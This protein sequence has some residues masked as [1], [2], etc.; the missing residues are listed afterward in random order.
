MRNIL[1]TGAKGFIGKNLVT[2][3]KNEKNI[4]VFEFDIN[5]SLDQLK[6]YIKDVDFIFHLAGINRPQNEEE[7]KTGNT[8][9]TKTLVDLVKN[10]KRN[11]PIVV[12]S[13]T[14]AVKDNPY[15]LSKKKAEDILLKH[16]SKGGNVFIYRLPNVFGKWC[17]PNYNSV[18]ATFCHNLARNIEI[19]V[20]NRENKLEFVYIDDV[21]EEFVSILMSEKNNLNDYYEVSVSYKTTLGELED[22]LRFISK[23]RETLMVPSFSD[24]FTRKL[25]ATYLSYLPIDN[26]SYDLKKHSDERGYLFE[27]IKSNEFGQ[28]FI[29][30]T[31][32][33]I[34]RGNHYHHTKFEKFCVI[35]G[36]A[37]IS[38]RHI[39]NNEKVS[40]K[41]NGDN[42]KIVDIPTGYTH[43]ITNVGKTDLITLFWV[44]EVFDPNKMD[45]YFETV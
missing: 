28:I 37:E 12:S 1:V 31:K 39:S 23:N 25:H 33:G 34:T 7:F 2:Q 27:V 43:N 20:S 14:Q 30:T 36:E 13:S 18:V 8:D 42:P 16:K 21:V 4:K 24:D 26:F 38:F 11:I 35:S 6:A 32:P 41:V 29:S 22:K 15:G 40:Y 17:K 19:N 10:E 3:L 44:D 45:T 5:N 9:F